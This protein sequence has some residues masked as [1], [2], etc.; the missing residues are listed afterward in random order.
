[1]RNKDSQ[2]IFEAYLK[3]NNLNK[4]MVSTL[5]E[6][7]DYDLQCIH[8]LLEE[9]G[10]F[11]KAKKLGGQALGAVQSAGSAV[12]KAVGQAAQAVGNTAV[13]QAVKQSATAVGNAVV[14]GTGAVGRAVGQSVQQGV[15]KVTQSVV[16]SLVNTLIA[17]I[18]PKQQQAF[19]DLIS[20]KA[21]LPADQ[22]QLISKQVTST[23]IKES[24]DSRED[25]KLWL[26]QT[27]FTE[28]N[29]RN[30]LASDSTLT[31]ASNTGALNAL[32]KEM[33]G[34]IQALYPKNKKAMAAAL[35][36]VTAGIH[37]ALGIPQ[38]AAQAMATA[39]GTA[40]GTAATTASTPGT[41]PA[42]SG[43]TTTAGTPGTA[44][45]ASGGLLKQI[46]TLA[47]K[48]PKMSA[49]TAA[50]IIGLTVAAFSSVGIVPMLTLC[51]SRAAFAGATGAATSV[52]KQIMAGQNVS[53]KQVA[54]DAA[55]G[56]AFGAAGAILGTG[57]SSL[58]KMFSGMFGNSGGA[59]QA[60]NAPQTNNT[61]IRGAAPT[62][63]EPGD[64]A[65]TSQSSANSAV[66]QVAAKNPD[67]NKFIHSQQGSRYL[68]DLQGLPASEIEKLARNRAFKLGTF[69]SNMVGDLID[70]AQERVKDNPLQA[71]YE[72]A[73][74]MGLI[75][76]GEK[77]QS[78]ANHIVDANNKVFCPTQMEA[79]KEKLMVLF[80]LLQV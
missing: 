22:V 40:P 37:N 44:P 20:G 67:F 45:A 26:A 70:N 13:G 79:S 64:V 23:P 72:Q 18:D 38:Q 12:G 28:E 71:E 39:D 63:P 69:D 65:S 55:M 15:A 32:A 56:G 19:I 11:D 16:Q 21:A 36:K 24:V 33:A 57:L 1:M 17:K 73:K 31:E 4:D 74:K 53:G 77:V 61:Q 62:A 78:R 52:V 54:K 41:A 42:A 35:P 59:P 51:L 48:Y 30:A 60:G 10:W 3:T 50:G 6:M 5:T 68:K 34:K 25:Y 66:D 58:G 14:Q 9:A 8:E 75:Q 76:N 47:T 43:S 7:R 46:M 2:L 29:L 80:K 49:V 27:L